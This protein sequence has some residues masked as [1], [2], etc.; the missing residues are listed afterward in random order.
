MSKEATTDYGEKAKQGGR[1]QMVKENNSTVTYA[2]KEI[3]RKQLK[4]KKLLKGK[5]VE[6]QK[7]KG[8]QTVDNEGFVQVNSKK[9]P[10]KPPIQKNIVKTGNSFDVLNQRK[11]VEPSTGDTPSHSTA[12]VMERH[13]NTMGETAEQQQGDNIAKVTTPNPVGAETRMVPRSGKG[14]G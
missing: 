7:G 4:D 11:D 8:G 5:Q 6:T 3:C 14:G 9:A 10:Q 13:S 2:R 12:G 1:R